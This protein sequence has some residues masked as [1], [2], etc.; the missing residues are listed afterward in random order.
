MAIVERG[1]N[2]FTVGGLICTLVIAAWLL[3]PATQ[4]GAETLT[5]SNVDNRII[6]ALR[7]GQ[8][9]LQ[10]W[11]PAPWQVNPIAKGPFKEANLYVIFMDRLLNQDA[12]GKP[13]AGG[14]FRSVALVAPAKHTQTGE[15]AIFVIR[16]FTPHEDLDLNNHYKNSVRATIRR[17]QTMKSVDLGPGTGSDLW[18][19]RDSAGGMLRFRMEYQRAV[20]SRAKREFKPRSAVEPT[21]FR[22]YRLDQGS[23]LVK[24]IPAGI[25]RVQNYQLSVTVSE[26]RKLF[27]GT[28]QLVGIVVIP[29]YVRRVYLP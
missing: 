27:D 6:V 5:G 10:P 14:T 23:D 13:A 25:D 7:V 3:V 18:E 22:I 17:E 21:F 4:A 12:Q 2:T 16:V 11:L 15:S 9:E 8:A 1:K 29:W 28:E 19:L 26:L 24:S 20:P